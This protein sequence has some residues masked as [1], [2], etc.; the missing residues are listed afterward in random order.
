MS[1]DRIEHFQAVPAEV[2]RMRQASTTQAY[3]HHTS[4][5]DRSNEV[6]LHIRTMRHFSQVFHKKYGVTP[7]EYRQVNTGDKPEK[8][9]KGLILIEFS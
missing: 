5:S 6:A 7:S 1:T 9:V 3:E 4:C 2:Q 8:C